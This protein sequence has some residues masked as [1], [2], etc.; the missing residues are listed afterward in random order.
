MINQAF[1][2]DREQKMEILTG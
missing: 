1:S 2:L